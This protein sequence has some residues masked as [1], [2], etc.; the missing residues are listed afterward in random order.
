MCDVIP[1]HKKSHK[2][3]SALCTAGRRALSGQ[4]PEHFHSHLAFHIRRASTLP[5]LL[6]IDLNHQQISVSLEVTI[7]LA[8]RT[9]TPP[10]QLRTN[11]RTCR[12]V[13]RSI[14]SENFSKRCT[15]GSTQRA[16]GSYK[17]NKLFRK[18]Y[19]RTQGR[20]SD[21]KPYQTAQG[22]SGFIP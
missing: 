18:I 15:S 12:K 5:L 4:Y 9:E 17:V 14:L 11:A 19:N 16:F 6:I 2:Q 3:D 10:A 22:H 8:A 7:L 1:Y 13:P 21:T 20:H